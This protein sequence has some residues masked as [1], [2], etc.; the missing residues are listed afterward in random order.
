MLFISWKCLLKV[1][2]SSLLKSVYWTFV[3]LAFQLLLEHLLYFEVQTNF[4]LV[5]LCECF[6]NFLSCQTAPPSMPGPAGMTNVPGQV[7]QAYPG[8]MSAAMAQ[9]PTV[10]SWTN[11]YIKYAESVFIIF[12]RQFSECKF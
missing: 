12:R 9:Q 3:C 6:V 5:V 7:N 1:L 11:I 2:T 10:V 8:Q 4:C